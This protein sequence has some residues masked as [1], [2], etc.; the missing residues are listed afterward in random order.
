M[1]YPEGREVGKGAVGW[2][3]R[4]GVKGPLKVCS[5]DL[6]DRPDWKGERLQPGEREAQGAAG[7]AAEPQE[8]GGATGRP[9]RA[10]PPCSQHTERLQ[11]PSLQ[12]K[13]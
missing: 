2:Q 13:H 10:L 9:E 6:S 5:E 12:A 7:A 1:A 3:G 4:P 11:T 8:L